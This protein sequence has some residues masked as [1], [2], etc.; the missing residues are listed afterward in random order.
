MAG[1]SSLVL[2]TTIYNAYKSY[3]KDPI[4]PIK[5]LIFSFEMSSEALLAKMLSMHIYEEYKKVLPYSDILSFNNILSQEDYK[6]I[7]QSK[8]WLEKFVEISTI[9]K[10]GAKL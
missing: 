9:I 6:L 5:F 2:Y 7:E 3:L 8:S 10:N 1:K 4:I